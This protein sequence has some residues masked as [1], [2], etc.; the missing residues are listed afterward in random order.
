MTLS[1]KLCLDFWYWLAI[2]KTVDFIGFNQV[3]RQVEWIILIETRQC[4]FFWVIHG[5]ERSSNYFLKD[6]SCQIV[7]TAF[8]FTQN[9]N[10]K[11][12]WSWHSSHKFHARD[13]I[14]I[15]LTF[16]IRNLWEIGEYHARK[17]KTI[18]KIRA[19]S[20]A[21]C[22]NENGNQ[23]IVWEKFYLYVQHDCL[24]TNLES[25]KSKRSETH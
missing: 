16:L 11:M 8:N 2:V 9:F 15:L 10:F 1:T 17:N 3:W 12:I 25:Y 14:I 19:N 6:W 22:F 18:G 24:I 23:I 21:K 4:K 5:P 7:D 20:N 13:I